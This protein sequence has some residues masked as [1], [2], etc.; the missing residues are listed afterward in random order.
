MHAI[1]ADI[2]DTKIV[3]LFV[4]VHL[5]KRRTEKSTKMALR[6]VCAVNE[7]KEGTT[8]LISCL[9]NLLQRIRRHK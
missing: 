9:N 1:L 8:G 4:E 6:V 3:S 5:V 7:S 2:Q